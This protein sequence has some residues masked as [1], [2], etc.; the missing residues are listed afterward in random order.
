[1]RP[2]PQSGIN[3][4]TGPWTSAQVIHLLRRATFG[5]RKSEVDQLLA[6]GMK[7][8]VDKLMDISGAKDPIPSP[9]LNVYSTPAEPDPTTPYGQTFVNAPAVT[10]I[11]PQYYQHAPM[12]LKPG[13]PET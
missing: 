5:V 3:P 4:Y 2:D 7:A 13:G 9:P 8:A 6:L 12:C 10:P 1:M 11:P